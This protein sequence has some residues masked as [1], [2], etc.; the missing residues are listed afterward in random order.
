[1][2]PSIARFEE[3]PLQ[4]IGD[5][6]GRYSVG[7]S[8][9]AAEFIRWLCYSLP[10]QLV[11]LIGTE[12]SGGNSMDQVVVESISD[13]DHRRKLCAPIPT[14]LRPVSFEFGWIG[15]AEADLHSKLGKPSGSR[16]SWQQFLF[17]GKVPLPYQAPGSKEPSTVEYDVM[18]YIEVKVAGGKVT[19][20]RASRSTTY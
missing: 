9:D 11:W 20:I 5:R 15:S 13:S 4:E 10:G 14:Q 16:H 19:A 7:Q 18:A 2:V 8:G 1:M 6:L 17:A 3:T 12:M